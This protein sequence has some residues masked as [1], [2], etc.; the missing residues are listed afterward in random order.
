M[1]RVLVSMEAYTEA[2]RVSRF[3]IHEDSGYSGAQGYTV[4]PNRVR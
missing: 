2:A 3:S 4:H 1:A